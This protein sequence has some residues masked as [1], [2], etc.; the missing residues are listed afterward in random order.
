MMKKL[1]LVLTFMLITS[2]A[3]AE[4]IVKTTASSLNVRNHPSVSTGVVIYSL[5][6]GSIASVIEQREQWIKIIFLSHDIPRVAKQGWIS[7]TYIENLE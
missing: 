5:P 7:S 3:S 1:L 6:K 2:A 4:M